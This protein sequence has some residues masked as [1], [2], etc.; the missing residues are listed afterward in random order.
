MIIKKIIKIG[1]VFAILVS[2]FLVAKQI[3]HYQE[4]INIIRSLV[5]KQEFTNNNNEFCGNTPDDR[6]LSFQEFQILRKYKN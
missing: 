4:T 6:C 1:I 3:R 5:E 2:C